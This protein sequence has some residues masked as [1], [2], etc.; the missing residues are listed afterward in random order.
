VAALAVA[1]PTATTMTLITTRATVS[2]ALMAKE[3]EAEV[4]VEVG[5]V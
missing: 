4:G 5:N 3:V 1:I 2:L